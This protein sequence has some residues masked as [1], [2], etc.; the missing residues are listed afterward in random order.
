MVTRQS[1]TRTE[2]RHVTSAVLA[3]VGVT[4]EEERVRDVATE[5]T[6]HVD[7]TRET[8]DRRT[9]NREP[10]GSDN[11]VMIGLDDFGLPVDHQTE[12][13]LHRN[14]RQWLERRVECQATQDHKRR[15]RLGPEVNKTLT[16]CRDRLW[17]HREP[18]VTI[19]NRAFR[20]SEVLLLDALRDRAGLAGAN[21]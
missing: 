13:A 8:D 3:L 7:E 2:F 4:R 17:D 12:R 1:F 18:A 21:G 16:H 5:A 20:D 6:R 14:H 11:A 15:I 9:R 19:G 10:L